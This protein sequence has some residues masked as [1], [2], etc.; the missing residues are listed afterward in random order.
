MNL[1]H[2]FLDKKNV[3]SSSVLVIFSLLLVSSLISPF[4]VYN[5]TAAVD[6]DTSG[7]ARASAF[8]GDKS[9]ATKGD[10]ICSITNDIAGGK[11]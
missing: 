6:I 5:A 3:P 2:V 10:T 1:S 9:I 4:Q 7:N 8:D 11:F